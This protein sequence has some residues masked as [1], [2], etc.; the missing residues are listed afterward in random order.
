MVAISRGLL[1][2]V[3][4][5]KLN[6]TLFGQRELHFF[7]GQ[8]TE[9]SS[10][11]FNSLDVVHNLGDHDTFLLGEIFTA[12]T[13]KRDGLVDASLDGFGVGNFDSNVGGSDNRYIVSGF[14]SDLLAVFAVSTISAVSVVSVMTV[15]LVS[16]L[17]DSDHLNIFL[18]F[19]G[20]FDS[21]GIGALFLLLVRVRADFVVDFFNGFS[22]HGAGDSVAHF[23][24][25]NTLDGQVNIFASGHNGGSADFSNFGHI[26]NGAVVLG[27]FVT[28]SMA[29][30]TISRSMVTVGR[31]V[32]DRGM[33]GL[34]MIDG[35][36]FVD[37]FV[38]RGG[39]VDGFMGLVGRFRLVDGGSVVGR[40]CGVLVM[41]AT[42]VVPV[43]L[44]ESGDFDKR[45]GIGQSQGNQS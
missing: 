41:G 34:G 2:S 35:G 43:F 39:F 29:M 22:A 10:A 38:S 27:F 12:D 42:V 24:V 18:L 37:R 13:G 40:G 32:V 30:M 28:I 8:I 14:L 15:S 26:L 19:E 23:F 16:G 33:V 44:S 7:A 45:S 20:D 1:V 4:I 25:D 31:G 6:T 9:S 5:N 36:G 11:F 3:S 21:L 17:A